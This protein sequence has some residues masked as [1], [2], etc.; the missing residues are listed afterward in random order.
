[1]AINFNDDVRIYESVPSMMGATKQSAFSVQ[2]HAVQVSANLDRRIATEL[3]KHATDEL[4]YL[5]GMSPRM[6][7]ELLHFIAHDPEIGAR[8]QA[9]VA[10][11]RMSGDDFNR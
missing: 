10:A 8:F 6:L 5:A 9:H 1:M 7:G 4:A 11:S 3:A 2:E